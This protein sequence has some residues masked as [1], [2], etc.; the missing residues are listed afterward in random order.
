MVAQRAPSLS[1]LTLPGLEVQQ[2][3]PVVSQAGGKAGGSG[4]RSPREGGKRG[5]LI[6]HHGGRPPGLTSP[7]L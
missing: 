4:P 7:R 2:G 3:S 5:V 6:K 1:T